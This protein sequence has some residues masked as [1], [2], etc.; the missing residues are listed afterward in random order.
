VRLAVVSTPRSGNTWLRILASFLYQ[1]EHLAAYNPGEVDWEHL[2]ESCAFQTHWHRTPALERDIND[3]G[4]R[5]ATLAR[6]PL[7]VLV[8]ILHFVRHEPTS[9]WLEGEGG[10]EESILGV[11][12]T[13]RAFLDYAA[14]PRARALLSVTAEWWSA[15]L[16]HR[17]R[18]ED[19]VADPEG[20]AARLCGFLGVDPVVRIG[21][22][23]EAARIEKLR[24]SV[25]NEH[26][27]QGTP[28]LWKRLL[29]ADVAHRIARAHAEVFRA[30]GY[31]ADPDETL[32]REDGEVNW[33]RLVSPA[34][35]GTR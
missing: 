5:V 10:G 30:L 23:V 9:R 22:A 15:P 1:V 35:A 32:S 29:P 7:D 25:T 28:G 13:S 12:P 34:A 27:W 24:P 3:A 4:F 17:M 2:P 19:L 26:F 8:S 31:G 14:G 21:D 33:E 11:G 20:E 16:V 6:H 18:Y